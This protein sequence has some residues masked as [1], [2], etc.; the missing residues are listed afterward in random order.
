MNDPA[1]N[2]NHEDRL[3]FISVSNFVTF[4]VATKL[5]KTSYFLECYLWV[6]V[7]ALIFE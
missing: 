6:L 1:H 4:P 3:I 5:S 2:H 7:N